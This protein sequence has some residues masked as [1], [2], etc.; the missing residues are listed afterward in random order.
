M[1][2]TGRLP[3]TPML[4]A[5]HLHG[6]LGSRFPPGAASVGGHASDWSLAVHLY[7][8][9]WSLA[10]SLVYLVTAVMCRAWDSWRSRFLEKSNSF[11]QSTRQATGCLLYILYGKSRSLVQLN[12]AYFLT[13]L[14]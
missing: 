10:W 3:F 2:V 11:Q 1:Q 7:V 5:G 9:G 6:C 12:V 13:G 8:M 14:C 4:S